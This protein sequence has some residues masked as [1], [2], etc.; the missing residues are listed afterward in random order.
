M[1]TIPDTELEFRVSRAG[2]PGGQHVNKTSTR[3][4][5]LWDVAGT[6]RLS[7]PE[8][9]RVFQKLANRIGADGVLRV[10]SE[11][12]R[13]QLQNRM[14]A[15]ERLIELVDAARRAPK[16]RKATKP[17]RAAKAKRLN[18]K[19]QRGDRKRDRSR[20]GWED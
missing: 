2:G 19:R 18:A 17:S 5:A 3:V 12:R 4:E 1:F 6:T 9:H 16:P 13:S 10:V 11:D 15:V 8:R 20:P 14:A 7:E